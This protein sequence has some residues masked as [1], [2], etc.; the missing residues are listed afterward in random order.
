MSGHSK[1]PWTI[2]ENPEK[3]SDEY[4]R[5]PFWIDGKGK[6]PIA[7]IRGLGNA[8]ENAH[9]ISS[10]PDMLEVLEAVLAM[11]DNGAAHNISGDSIVRVIRK[12][13]GE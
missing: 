1:G 3:D 4:W 5:Y 2:R 10:A 6:E 12:A 13:K 8:E 9:L 11:V 7:D